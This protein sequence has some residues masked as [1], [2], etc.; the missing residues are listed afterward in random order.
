MNKVI[1]APSLLAADFRNL[2]REFEKINSS[3]AEWIHFDV[4]DGQN[5]PNISFGFPLLDAT[6]KLT[7]KYIDVH[8]MIENPSKYFEEFKKYGADGLTIHFENQPNIKEQLQTIKSLGMKAGLVINPDTD[9]A[10]LERYLSEL[11][12]ILIMSVFPG[13]GGQKF[14][15]ATYD[16]V[17]QA[18]KLIEDSGRCIILQVDGGVSL[19]NSHALICAGA[20]ALVCGSAL[21]KE[22]NF[23]G[24]VLKLQDNI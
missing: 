19:N 8:L 22:D 23:E 6:R 9:V 12:L 13:F 2:E 16:R 24:Y 21:F 11:D 10:V 3:E 20:D 15:D 18:R 5:V 17:K 7:N 14:I 4:M 1:I